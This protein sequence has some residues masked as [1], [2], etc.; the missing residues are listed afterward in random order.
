[1]RLLYLIALRLYGFAIRLVAFFN[2]KAALWVAGRRQWRRSHQ[3]M[4][5]ARPSEGAPLVWVHCASLGEFEQGRPVIEGLKQARPGVKVLLSFFSPSGYSLRKNYEQ[6]DYVVY[7]PLDTPANARSFLSIWKPALAVFVKYEFWYFHLKALHQ[8]GVPTLLVSA[9][10]RPGQLFFRSW[11][12]PFRQVPAWFKHIFVQ[13]EASAALLRAKG[14]D[15]F[16][17][18]GDTRIDRVMQIAEQTPAFPLVEAFCEQAHVL[19]AG[20]TWPGDEALLIPFLNHHLPE[21]WKAIIA[22]HQ[23]RAAHIQTLSGQLQGKACIYSEA[24]E[25]ALRSARVLLIDNVG[26]LSALYQYGRLAYIGGGFGAGIHNTLEPIAFGLPVI[27]G[28]KYEKF[29]EARFLVSSGAGFSISQMAELHAAFDALLPEAAYREASEKARRYLAANQGA[30]RA[31]VAA[32]L[33]EME[34]S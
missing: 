14:L 27:F 15:N 16:S 5:E 29:E 2:G 23:I 19:I 17:V 13:N 30:S 26:M 12:G 32:I 6:A 3:A 11:G 33:A 28:P 10:F 8:A 18:A 4:Q 9:L 34:N 24:D 22:P 7:L 20:S 31:A 21:G 1:M 25:A